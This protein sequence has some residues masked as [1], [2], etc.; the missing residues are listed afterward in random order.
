MVIV[1]GEKLVKTLGEKHLTFL[2]AHEYFHIKRNH[3]MKNVL[4]FIF[5]L[6][7]VPIAL[8]ILTSVLGTAIPI[9]PIVIFAFCAYVSS[10][11]LHFV[12]SQRREFQAD[13]FASSIVGSIDARETLEMIKLLHLTVFFLKNKCITSSFRFLFHKQY[14]GRAKVVVNR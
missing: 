6:S 7:G 9:V 5:V 14:R 11:I 13:Q 1:C 3:L 8:L 2:I 12:F 4:S 10:F